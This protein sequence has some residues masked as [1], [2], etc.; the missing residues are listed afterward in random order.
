M[1]KERLRMQIELIRRMGKDSLA[2]A[3]KVM[4][5]IKSWL[6]ELH[7]L[8]RRK[9]LENSMKSYGYNVRWIDWNHIY[10]WRNQK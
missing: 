5:N 7:D 1:K 4:N 9:E 3:L 8:T 2:R 10:A 6:I